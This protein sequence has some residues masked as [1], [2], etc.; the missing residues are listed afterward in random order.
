MYG[1]HQ[2]SR[3]VIKWLE[4]S[5]WNN[6]FVPIMVE[7]E[8]IHGMRTKDAGVATKAA[9]EAGD[10]HVWCISTVPSRFCCR[11]AP[12]S[13]FAQNDEDHVAL[14]NPKKTFYCFNRPRPPATRCCNF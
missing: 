11:D 9:A 14:K 6:C 12:L 4:R 3:M 8:G 13:G 10:G 1:L 2:D 5:F 7:E